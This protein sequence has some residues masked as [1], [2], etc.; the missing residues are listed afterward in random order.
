MSR[1]D[2]N[3][4]RSRSTEADSNAYRANEKI[5]IKG[6][7]VGVIESVRFQ[8]NEDIPTEY[9]ISF[10]DGET[11]ESMNFNET[12]EMVVS[13][14][15]TKECKL[16]LPN[17][18]NYLLEGYK[19]GAFEKMINEMFTSRN[20]HYI[21]LEKLLR[22][23]KR[24]GILNH[25]IDSAGQETSSTYLPKAIKNAER[26]EEDFKK[27]FKKMLVKQFYPRISQSSAGVKRTTRHW[28][29]MDATKIAEYLYKHRKFNERTYKDVFYN[30]R[31][32]TF[33]KYMLD[34]DKASSK[35]SE[36]YQRIPED[37][38]EEDEINLKA[39]YTEIVQGILDKKY[40]K[41]EQH[42][43]RMGDAAILSL[44][45]VASRRGGD[46]RKSRKRTRRRRRRKKYSKK[47]NRKL[48]KKSRKRK[49]RKRKRKKRT[50]RRR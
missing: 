25:A 11:N 9:K 33:D 15:I 38:L 6:K 4:L 22:R 35:L 3:D 10:D 12:G 20:A 8:D 17:F 46:K 14:V 1:N 24:Y 48:K 27:I 37:I 40:G 21:F 44:G 36:S 29:I 13:G 32:G 50:R 45:R 47:S 7:E 31:Y 49:S 5:C 30:V 41:D 26:F 28:R 42:K 2:Q 23:T 34:V 43:M 18:I 39:I 16:N 19:Q